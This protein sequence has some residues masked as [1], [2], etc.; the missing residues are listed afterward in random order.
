MSNTSPVSLLISGYECMDQM[1]GSCWESIGY[2]LLLC[3]II[4]KHTAKTYYSWD[5]V[6]DILGLV[7]SLVWEIPGSQIATDILRSLISI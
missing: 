2:V 4:R 7:H 5:I 3:N 6:K 1:F